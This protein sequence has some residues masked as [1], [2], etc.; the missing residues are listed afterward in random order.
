MY[1]KIK[2]MAVW[3][4]LAVYILSACNFPIGSASSKD[5]SQP[6]LAGAGGVSRSEKPA[7]L[8]PGLSAA[9]VEFEGQV[10]AKSALE[11]QFSPASLG[12]VLTAGSQLQTGAD[13]RARVDFEDGTILRISPVTLFTLTKIEDPEEGLIKNLTLTFGKIW[14]ILNG[15]EMNVE[16][17]SGVASVSGS[18]MSV[19]S[20][21]DFLYMTCLEGI[22]SWGEGEEQ[23]V[24]TAGQTLLV[25]GAGEDP[26]EGS[27]TDEEVWEWL[28]INPEV[29]AVLGTISNW[30]WEDANANGLQDEGEAGVPEVKITLL[31]QADAELAETFSDE[32]GFYLFENVPGGSFKI[33]FDAPEG[34]LFTLK[35]AGGDDGLDS[36]A[37]ADGLT[38][39][40]S[41]EPGA[42]T[43]E[44][45]AGLVVSHTGGGSNI[46]PLT[47]LQVKDPEKLNLRPIFVSIS[48]FPP[49]ATR[50]PTAVSY[51]PMV[52]ELYIGYGQ[53]RLFTLFYCDYPES[54]GENGGETPRIEGVRSGRVAY[55]E[56]ADFFD[57][58]MIIGG[59]DPKVGAQI[60]SKVCAT[61]Y[62]PEGSNDIGAGGLDFT[63]LENIADEC[64]PNGEWE[65]TELAVNVFGPPPA[66]G[67]S[68]DKFMM[69]YNQSN[70]T[71]WTYSPDLG[72]YVRSQNH[73]DTPDQ[74][75]DSIDKLNGAPLVFENI[76]VLYTQHTVENS[77]GTI[78]N[79]DLHYNQGKAKLFRSGMMYEICWTTLGNDYPSGK[80]QRFRPILYTDC[81]G[82][83][84]PLAAGQTWVN[85]VDVTTGFFFDNDFGE[86][87]ARFYQPS[88]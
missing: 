82:N 56:I 66:G 68:G 42:S 85:L 61:A 75:E 49:N 26:I 43:D 18:Y 10:E 81:A 24:L 25:S 22:C 40:F 9:L 4:I 8:E 78:I 21:G 19:E 1:L 71:R 59:V 48:H 28:A 54:V 11:D 7:V 47:G 2:K 74:F 27:T 15:G 65:N 33:R 70:K 17:E 67:Q 79:M 34:Y 73:P 6:Q 58:G 14:I 87:V 53:T 35:D 46:C 51:A 88:P 83:L 86:W 77:A 39:P 52:F 13:S 50:P 57:A 30:V 84:F 5:N 16:T 80:S 44:F 72:G 20:D 36:D 37:A 64:R 45:D 38:D 55:A 63:R 3:G 76:V 23:I 29:Q 62:R 12:Y 69:N 31:D 32:E 60:G 41:L